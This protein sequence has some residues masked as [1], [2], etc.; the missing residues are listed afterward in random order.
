MKKK[1]IYF[2]VQSALI[3]AIYAAATYIAAILNI[4]YGPIQFRFSEALNILALFTPAAIPGLTIGCFIAN[5]GSPYGVLDMALGT[6]ATF[7]SAFCIYFIARKVKKGKVYIAPIFPTLFN[8]LIIGTEIAIFL[9]SGERW[10]GFLLSAGQ[11]GLGEAAVC[12]VL[13]IPLYY[14]LE[15]RFTNLLSLPK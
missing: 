3:A 2:I 9:P 1:Q 15:K 4:A 8:A 10:L 6:L 12:F 7:L 5:L 11:I 13:G 14:L